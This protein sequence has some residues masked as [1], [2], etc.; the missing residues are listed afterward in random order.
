MGPHGEHKFKALEAK[1]KIDPGDGT[2]ARYDGMGM[3]N[4]LCG[5]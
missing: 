5:S 4:Y 3:L 2:R 1:H